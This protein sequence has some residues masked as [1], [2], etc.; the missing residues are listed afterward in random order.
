[1]SRGT[2]EDVRTNEDEKWET[3]EN[4]LTRRDLQGNE[5]TKAKAQKRIPKQ[6]KRGKP[7]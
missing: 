1:L 3:E 4:K 5:Q 2:N 6:T 7:S